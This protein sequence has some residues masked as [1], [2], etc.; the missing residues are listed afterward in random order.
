MDR[1]TA[2]GERR[3][4]RGRA[5]NQRFVGAPDKFLQE[6]RLT[7]TG[8]A[9]D[10]NVFSRRVD[11]VHDVRLFGREVNGH[12]SAFGRVFQSTRQHPRQP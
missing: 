1:L 8:T 10:K 2:N 6:G 11:N 7:R 12:G 9:R 5:N 3:D 4:A